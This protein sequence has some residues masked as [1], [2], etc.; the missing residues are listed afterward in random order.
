MW[1]NHSKGGETMRRF[2]K[3]NE[4][5]FKLLIVTLLIF[6]MFLSL[7]LKQGEIS[8]VINHILKIISP[9]IYGFVLAFLIRPISERIEY[10]LLY[11]CKKLHIKRDSMRMPAV[12]LAIAF[13]L[14]IV[15]LL[16]SAV[17][18]GLIDSI[19]SLIINLPKDIAR[20]RSWLV[21]YDNGEISHEITTTINQAVGTAYTYITNMIRDKWL[22]NIETVAS[23][24]TSSMSVIMSVLKNFGL[25]II[26]AV[27][28]LT[29]WEKFGA[30]IRLIIIAVF[31]EKYGN[32]ILKELAYSH[33]MFY[34]FI[35]GKLLDSFIIGVICFIYTYITHTPYGL[36]VSVIVGVTNIIPFFGPYI[37]M[38]P[39][40]ILIF[41]IDK[42]LCVL[43]LLFINILQQIDGNIIGP[44]I[45][46]D[47]LGISSFWILFAILFFGGY[48]GLVGMIVGVPLFAVIYD[49]IRHWIFK[50]LH[51]DHQDGLIDEYNETYAT[52]KVRKKSK[53]T[54]QLE[55]Y[56]KK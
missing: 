31:N 41:T 13:V 29:S 5:Y 55:K 51:H 24:A 53:W 20:F 22:P 23:H 50:E 54:L 11:I 40:A 47:K 4:K 27:Y 21:T 17:I 43:F 26:I 48:W 16:M 10:A 12:L 45:L 34:G 3:E 2:L 42:G 38:I 19:S 46:G 7:F 30:Q 6:F 49:I 35:S 15:I 36:L 56:F 39:S 9:F 18:P 25:G 14:T 1:Y 8:S 28:L 32:W 44:M 33:D 52:P 37:G